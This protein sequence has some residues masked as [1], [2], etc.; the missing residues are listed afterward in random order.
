MKKRSV[1]FIVEVIIA[2]SV[3]LLLLGGLFAVQNTS[4]PSNNLDKLNERIEICV[5]ALIE[6]GVVFD[7]FD[8]VNNRV[9]NSSFGV[10]DKNETKQLIIQAV[11][12]ALPITALF[13]ISTSFLHNDSN[14]FL[15]VDVINGPINPISKPTTYYEYYTQGYYSQLTNSFVFNSYKFAVQAWY[16][17]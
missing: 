8:T 5:E 4:T 13:S 14:E 3:M 12:T 11:T 9:L 6:K 17:G 1:L 16:E 15:V 2:I 7:Y 10:S